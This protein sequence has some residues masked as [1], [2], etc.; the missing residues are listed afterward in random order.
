[1]IGV[2][3]C[4]SQSTPS[5]KAMGGYFT[6]NEIKALFTLEND[7]VA[8]ATQQQLAAAHGSCVDFDEVSQALA[9]IMCVYVCVCVWGGSCVCV[10]VC[11]CVCYIFELY[12]T[13]AYE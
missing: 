10:C 2:H 8:S 12:A 13:H 4:A 11:V 3:V 7:G 9:H 1:M 6:R 5:K